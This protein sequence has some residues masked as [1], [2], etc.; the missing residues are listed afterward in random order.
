MDYFPLTIYTPKIHYW[1]LID[2][3]LRSAAIDHHV[4]IKMLISWWN[5][6]RTSEDYFLKSLMHITNSYPKVSI[7][8]V[9]FILF[10]HTQ[11]T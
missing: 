8:I 9:C 3:A 6:S 11:F 4:N 7:E 1:P 10:T 5:H 2:N